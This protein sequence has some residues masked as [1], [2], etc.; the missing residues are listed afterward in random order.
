[1]GVGIGIGGVLLILA[2]I[3]GYAVLRW[4]RRAKGGSV[5]DNL[6]STTVEISQQVSNDSM[7]LPPSMSSGTL[8]ELTRMDQDEEME[9]S[10]I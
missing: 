9:K 2:L 7:P 10:R 6:A 1:M 4:R 5:P 3:G 8:E